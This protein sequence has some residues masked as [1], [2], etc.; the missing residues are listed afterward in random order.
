MQPEDIEMISKKISDLHQ[1]IKEGNITEE[2]VIRDKVDAIRTLAEEKGVPIY[3]PIED[4]IDNLKNKELG[5]P[6]EYYEEES[7]EYS[8]E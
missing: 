4:L 1:S 7:E 8:E 2:K 5:V 6:E 3:I